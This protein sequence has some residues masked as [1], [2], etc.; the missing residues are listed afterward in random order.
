MPEQRRIGISTTVPLEPFIASGTIPVD[1]NNLFITSAVPNEFVEEA[2]VRGYPRNICTWIKGLY[3]ASADVDGVVGVVRGDCSN[4][5]SLLETLERE[6]MEVHPFSYPI[7]RSRELLVEEIEALCDLLGCG[8]DE[9]EEASDR[10]E[11]LRSLAREIDERRWRHLRISAQEAHLAQVSTSDLDS[12][13]EGW[14]KRMTRLLEDEEERQPEKEGIR[15]G[16][17]GVPPIIT[18][19][20][21]RIEALGGN[22]IFFEVQRQFTMPSGSNDWVQRYL[23][24]TYPYDI[25]SRV[26]D[27]KQQVHSRKLDGII[28]YF[29]S[30]CHR[31]IDDMIFRKEL[32]I[33]LLAIEGN[34]PGPMDERTQIRLESF[35]DV[36]EEGGQ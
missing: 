30:F 18:D 32:D 31:Q 7:N 8:F 12:D 13:I 9:A 27:I 5:E 36:L 23:D 22:T 4:T 6:S 11:E 1:L 24:Y 10:V 3:T 2:Q 29:Q 16:Y 14:E 20:F 28:H 19:I 17:I 34:L 26:K 21:P 15:L 25:S 33:P 35:L